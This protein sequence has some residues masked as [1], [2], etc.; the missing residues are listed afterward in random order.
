MSGG[1]SFF[2][3]D[4]VEDRKRRRM[5][6]RKQRRYLNSILVARQGVRG[7]DFSQTEEEQV[8]EEFPDFNDWR[9]YFQSAG[10]KFAR[11]EEKEDA[12]DGI[13]AKA[14]GKKRRDGPQSE[15]ARV[16]A[17]WER[18]SR[19]TRKLFARS[20]L[21]SRFF[22]DLESLLVAFKFERKLPDC[23]AL[24]DRPP[25]LNA[26]TRVMLI[27][28][29]DSYERYTLHRLCRF[30]DLTS[31]TATTASSVNASAVNGRKDVTVTRPVRGLNH[32]PYTLEELLRAKAAGSKRG[33]KTG[34]AS[35]RR[36]RR[37]RRAAGP[38][39][40]APIHDSVN[41][42]ASADPADED[43]SDATT[44]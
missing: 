26:A 18:L 17:L 37:R 13:D 16:N 9:G 29:L 32:H 10:L 5:G 20:A 33:G 27:P 21:G 34:G 42:D 40:G 22:L 2:R 23:P 25:V 6:R 4:L 8:E 43:S 38:P 31:D 35:K 36:S 1:V 44:S 3:R 19:N 15:V 12:D 41:G 39:G 30:H 14:D 7:G 11:G 24:G 28:E